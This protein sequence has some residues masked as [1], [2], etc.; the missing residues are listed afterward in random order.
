MY[1]LHCFIDIPSM[2]NNTPGI[3]SPLGELSTRSKTFSREVGFYSNST[4]PDVKLTAL[5]SVIDGNKTPVSVTYRD[6]VLQVAQYLYSKSVD[7]ILTDNTEAARQNLN[8]AFNAQIEIVSMSAMVTNGTYWLPGGLVFRR[9]GD[10]ANLIKVWFSNETF[11][12]QYE[13]YEIVVVP[14]VD[15]LNDLHR[16]RAFVL[17]LLRA[18]TIPDHVR[19]SQRISDGKPYTYLISSNYD[20]VDPNDPQIR[21]PTPWTVIIYGEAG[22]NADIIRDT[23]IDYVL[24]NSTYTREQWEVIYPDLFLP[25]EY[26]ITPFWDRFSLPNQRLVSGLYSPTSKYSEHLNYGT[27]TFHGVPVEHI[28]REMTIC[29][30]TYKGLSFLA[31]SNAK[32]RDP[33]KSFDRMWPQYIDITTNS[34]DFNRIP[35]YTQNF[36]RRLI[37][38][39]VIADQ[40]D[41]MIDIPEGMSR[42]RRGRNDYLTFNYDTMQYLVSLKHNPVYTYPDDDA[43][44]PIVNY[45]MVI[46][47]GLEPE[48][49]VIAQVYERLGS[50]VNP[51]PPGTLVRWDARWYDQANT[52]LRS[53]SIVSGSPEELLFTTTWDQNTAG[54]IDASATILNFGS[55][56]IVVQGSQQLLV[57]VPNTNLQGLYLDPDDPTNLT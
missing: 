15:D 40:I 54:F 5:S 4:Y 30:T 41:Q 29:G 51:L 9:I 46:T 34:L 45:V 16:H 49:G 21:Q 1:A 50:V 25:N 35:P 24:D 10:D 14:P 43:V 18:I 3:D 8:S 44:E 33:R 17:A 42:V 56:P 48:S 47:V 36:I 12:R 37:E 19:K 53:N 23:L 38:A 28:R 27:S 22:N 57:L 13:L 6:L 11:R 26:Y 7:G 31:C 52:L 20:W 32:N 2:V 55:D 39:F